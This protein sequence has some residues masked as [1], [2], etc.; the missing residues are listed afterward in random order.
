[1]AG[2][3]V[4]RGRTRLFLDQTTTSA[5]RYRASWSFVP[6]EAS[7]RSPSRSGMELAFISSGVLDQASAPAG[8]AGLRDPPLSSHAKTQ[9]G[10]A[11]FGCPVIQRHRRE[12]DD[13]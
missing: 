13:P 10:R 1:M 2:G 3:C 7:N 5:L 12:F 4:F 11:S 9:E 8:D 6:A